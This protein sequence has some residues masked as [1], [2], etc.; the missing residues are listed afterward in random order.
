MDDELKKEIILENYTNPSNY[1]KVID[2]SYDK[3]NTKSESCID[4]LTN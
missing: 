1:E 4:N 2:T 3:F